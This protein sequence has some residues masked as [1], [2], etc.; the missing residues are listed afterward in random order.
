M[1]LHQANPTSATVGQDAADSAI[2]TAQKA[3]A[4]GQQ[5]LAGQCLA[6]CYSVLHTLVQMA[7]N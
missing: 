7:A 5:E 6:V 1:I 4:A 3:H 2:R